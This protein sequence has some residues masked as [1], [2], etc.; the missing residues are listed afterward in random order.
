MEGL[1]PLLMIIIGLALSASNRRKR[2]A[3][4]QRV[5]AKAAP[6]KAAA[7]KAPG[8]AGIPKAAPKP[9]AAPEKPKDAEIVSRDGSIVMPPMEAHEHEGKPL[10]C[11]AEERE[12][13]RPWH[14]AQ[15]AA[16]TSARPAALR[17]NFSRSSVVQAVVMAE[18]LSR[19][20]YEN[21]RRVIR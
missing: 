20:K 16:Q 21:G 5:P 11:P 14:A 4:A 10:P 18:V 1:L 12:R 17:L 15:A 19:P 2:Q 7:H 3:A 6:A 8:N 13:P 9:V